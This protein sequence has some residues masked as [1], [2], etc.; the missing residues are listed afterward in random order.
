LVV[1]RD[2]YQTRYGQESFAYITQ[3]EDGLKIDFSLWPLEMVTQ[4]AAQAA[5]PEDLDVG[6]QVLLDKDGLTTA[7]LPPSYRAHIPSPPQ[8]EEYLTNIEV[9]FHEATYVAKHL[10]RDDLLPAK[11]C[12]DTMLKGEK[13]LE[14]LI[15]ELELHHGWS[16][17]PGALGKGLKK[18]LLPERWAALER[19][20]VGSGLEEN[21]SALFQAIELFREAGREVGQALGF[22]YPE[23]LD[24]RAMNYLEK[25]ARLPR[26]AETFP[27]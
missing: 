22:A 7:L 10:W 16:L 12:F 21:W 9:F 13:L 3:Y 14:M 19:T 27:S 15:W 11:F 4:V 26:E 2:P 25:V 1:Y 24:R 18:Q 5:L 8:L 20:Y 6:Y 23:E 17:K